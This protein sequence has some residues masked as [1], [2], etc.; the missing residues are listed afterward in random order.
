MP[1]LIC[2]RLHTRTST[3]TALH[4]PPTHALQQHMQPTL[5]DG[6]LED[7]HPKRPTLESHHPGAFKIKAEETDDT[8]TPGVQSQCK[9]AVAIPRL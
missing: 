1:P 5:G 2:F 9:R 6:A 3:S 4:Q 7:E 8:S